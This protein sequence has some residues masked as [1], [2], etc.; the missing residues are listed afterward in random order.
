MKT[1]LFALVL[2]LSAGV[3]AQ[4]A[5]SFQVIPNP[6]HSRAVIE[7]HQI[8]IEK[9]DVAIF[10]LLGTPVNGIYQQIQR[11]DTRINLYFPD[12]P[13]GIYLIR[14]RSGEFDR[15]QRMKVQRQ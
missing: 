2:I 5:P 14:I 10:T 3:R 15:T 6:A 7:L 8:D 13:E 4:I 9:V 1:I 11:G 12:L